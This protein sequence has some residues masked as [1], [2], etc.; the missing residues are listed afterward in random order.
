MRIGNCALPLMVGTNE[1]SNRRT[2]QIRLRCNESD[3]KYRAAH[4]AELQ[5]PAQFGRKSLRTLLHTLLNLSETERP[6]FHFLI[7]DTPLRTTLDKY[8]ER[9]KLSFEKTVIVT[10]YLPIGSGEKVG[11]TLVSKKWLCS[12]DAREDGRVLAGSCG[13]GVSIVKGDEVVLEESHMPERHSSAV[14]GVQWLQE[15]HFLTV[16]TDQTAWVWREGK[17]DAE[18]VARLDTRDTKAVS[19]SAAA[20][21]RG[22]NTAVLGCADG[23]IWLVGDCVGDQVDKSGTGGKKR[24]GVGELSGSRMTDGRLR[25]TGLIWREEEEEVVAVGWDGFTSV[26]CAKTCTRQA[27]IPSGGKALTGVAVV[28]GGG[29][30]VVGAVD[31]GVRMVDG[32][33]GG[34]VVAACGKRGAHDGMVSDVT[35]AGAVVAS[36]G[37]DG[38]VKLWD[39]RSLLAP[40]GTVD[41]GGRLLAVHAVDGEK[42]AVFAAGERGRVERLQL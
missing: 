3:Q 20:V 1:N 9:R 29:A 12:L 25:V 16:S 40:V 41:C 17:G 34:G 15:E 33:L 26:F 10:Y 22:T 37:V 32:R 28:R 14:K 23:S 4:N 36:A 30:L 42:V 8:I 2:L 35:A 13:G 11:E 21:R 19:F 39:V 24:G 27:T 31:G 18:V 6:D 38:C 5:V 7:D